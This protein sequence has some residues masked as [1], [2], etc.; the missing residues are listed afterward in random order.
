MSGMGMTMGKKLICICTLTAVL[1]FQSA[2]VSYAEDG[3][4]SAS[5]TTGT[6]ITDFTKVPEQQIL[7]PEELQKLG[8]QLKLE[9]EQLEKEQERLKAAQ[10]QL[11]TEQEQLSKDQEQLKKEQLLLLQGQEQ[12]KKDREQ[13]KKDMD[14]LT[15]QS[16]RSKLNSEV[17]DSTYMKYMKDL[18]YYKAAFKD[19]KL[20]TRN[21]ILLFQSNHN[22]SLTGTWDTAT[23]NM[24][25]N[26][27]LSQELTYFDKVNDA[28]T[29]GKWIVVN[30]SKRI[31]T[32]YEGTKV[33]K[34][35][36][37]AVG[38]P[39]T[40]T[41]SGKYFINNKIVDPDWGGGGF[42]KP[43]KGGTPENP[44]GSRWMGIN[45]T[46]GSYGIHGTNSF[47]SIGKFISH[48][49][50]RM[51]NYMVEELFPLVPMKA[52]IWVGTQEE[53]KKWGITQPEFTPGN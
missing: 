5:K 51:Q 12:L 23:K 11:K 38:N 10:E 13:L 35:Y 20:N 22:M 27:L 30:K 34:K 7:S 42:A 15:L 14:K 50:I 16:K 28:P 37:V 36:P 4:V 29:T 18:G 1:I 2:A 6:A 52:P 32:L 19:E 39:H 48:G 17:S 46:D 33:L 3:G 43:V 26:R 53:L 25:V 24:L 40:L 21:A 9:K 44:L 45:R 41:K 47:Y 8:D 31:L 49:C